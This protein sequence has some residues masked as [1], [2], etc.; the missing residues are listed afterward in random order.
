M[1]HA[2]YAHFFGQPRD[3]LMKHVPLRAEEDEDDYPPIPQVPQTPQ[4]RSSIS[5]GWQTLKMT[6][7]FT[8]LKWLSREEEDEVSLTKPPSDPKKNSKKWGD[9]GPKLR[10]LLSNN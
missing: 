6:A 9:L 4:H 7:R 3:D 2:L 8:Q 5:A 10:R 1:E